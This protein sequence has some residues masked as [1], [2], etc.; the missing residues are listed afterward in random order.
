MIRAL[1]GYVIRLWQQWQQAGIRRAGRKADKLE[2]HGY[3]Q[4][5]FLLAGAATQAAVVAEPNVAGLHAIYPPGQAFWADPFVWVRDGRHYIFFEDFP[6]STWRGRISVIEVDESGRPLGEAVPVIEEDHHLSYPFLF[7]YDGELYMIPEKAEV[8]RVDLYRCVE[9]P[10]RW[11]R[12]KTLIDGIKIADPTL[13]EHEGRWWLLCAAKQGRVRINE[14]LF[15]YYADSP[16][17]TT[18]TPHAANPLVRDFRSGRPGGRIFRDAAGRLLRPSQD[19]LRRYGH[20]LNL[21]QIVRLTPTTYEEQRLWTIY[22]DAIGQRA[23]HHLDWQA[24][25]LVMDAQ[26]LL[27]ADQAA[28][29]TADEQ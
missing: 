26:R 28:A 10:L 27:L 24:G 13:I 9:F 22:G 18:W 17:S 12:V 8:K 2:E 3:Q 11:E 7:E 6:F 19:C 16:L 15:A 4:Q 1:F 25:M 29:Q 23:I 20:G 5:W 14:S 21:S